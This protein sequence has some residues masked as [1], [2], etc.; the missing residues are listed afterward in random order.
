MNGVKSTLTVRQEKCPTCGGRLDWSSAELA[1]DGRLYVE[2][3]RCHNKYSDGSGEWSP[4]VQAIL[5]QATSKYRQGAFEDAIEDLEIAIQTSPNCHEAYW[6]SLLAKNGIIYEKDNGFKPTCN[7]ANFDSFYEQ[8]DYKN[9]VKYAPE[10]MQKFYKEQAD[11]VEQIRKEIIALVEKEEPFDIFLSFKKTEINSNQP[12][13]DMM[14]AN[15]IYNDLS[16]KYKV[17]Y[18]EKSLKAGTN[19]EPTIFRALQSAKVFI[20][21]CSKG[22]YANAVW[23]KNEWSRYLRMMGDGL[24]KPETM[25]IVYP[26]T[27]PSSSMPIK[28]T[29]I[30]GIRY[31][32]RNYDKQMEEF[33]NRSFAKYPSENNIVRKTFSA[34]KNFGPKKEM[35][36]SLQIQRKEFVGKQVDVND[37]AIITMAKRYLEQSN[38]YGA[39][40]LCKSVLL[41]NPYSAAAKLYM[42]YSDE[43][44]RNDS[45]YVNGYK[46]RVNCIKWLDEI[47]QSCTDKEIFQ[48]IIDIVKAICDKAIADKNTDVIVE[49]FNLVAQWAP[50]KDVDSIRNTLLN[51][52]RSVIKQSI[53]NNDLA[54]SIFN[55]VLRTY[56]DNEVE[57]YARMN[58]EFA[59]CLHDVRLFDDALPYYNKSLELID[60]SQC[61]FDRLLCMN[62]LV[63]LTDRVKAKTV[64]EKELENILKF[65]D[66]S[67]GITQKKCPTCGG[68]L[69]M[70]SE[71][72]YECSRCYN[73]YSGGA[74]ARMRMQTDLVNF[75]LVQ[76]YEG[77]FEIATKVFDYVIQFVPQDDIARNKKYLVPFADMLLTMGQY[78]LSKSYYG[79][80][81]NIDDLCHEAHWGMLKAE[82]RCRSDRALLY[83]EYDISVDDHFIKAIYGAISNND[84]GSNMYYSSF[85]EM[86]LT[87][88]E[89]VIEKS[90][91]ALLSN[92]EFEE[93]MK[94]FVSLLNFEINTRRRKIS[95]HPECYWGMLLAEAECRSDLELF[96]KRDTFP[97]EE[98]QKHENCVKYLQSFG[99]Q[100]DTKTQFYYEGNFGSKKPPITQEEFAENIIPSHVN[101]LKIL[102]A[103]ELTWERKTFIENCQSA[104]NEKQA[105]ITA[106]QR[107][108]EQSARSQKSGAVTKKNLALLALVLLMFGVVAA[109]AYGCSV[110]YTYDV[111]GDWFRSLQSNLATVLGV[112]IGVP[113]VI[114]AIVGFFAIGEGVGGAFA[115]ALGGAVVGGLLAGIVFACCWALVPIVGLAIIIGCIIGIKAINKGF[116]KRVHARNQEVMR[117]VSDKASD[118][119]SQQYNT[120]ESCE[121]GIRAYNRRISSFASANGIDLESIGIDSYTADMIRRNRTDDFEYNSIDIDDRVNSVA[122]SISGYGTSIKTRARTAKLI[123]A[124]FDL[125]LLAIAAVAVILSLNCSQVY[126]TLHWGVIL[127]VGLGVLVV[128]ILALIFGKRYLRLRGLTVVFMI[129]SVLCAGWLLL[130]PMVFGIKIADAKGLNTVANCIAAKYELTD[131]IDCY[132]EEIKSTR[133]FRG[134]FNG[135]GYTISNMSVEG[136]WITYNEGEIYNVKFADLSV[137]GVQGNAYY[138]GLIDSNSGNASIHHIGVYN[139]NLLSYGGT[140]A[141]LVNTNYGTVSQIF[142]DGLRVSVHN[143]DSGTSLD[144]GG[145]VGYNSGTMSECAIENSTFS[146]EEASSKTFVGGLCGNIGYGTITDSYAYGLTIYMSDGYCSGIAGTCTEATV[147]RC[148]VDNVTA[149]NSSLRGIVGYVYNSLEVINCYAKNLSSVCTTDSYY[150]D[151][152]KTNYYYLSSHSLT[153]A[154]FVRNS[155]HLLYPVWNI[156][157]G[158]RPT[159]AWDFTYEAYSKEAIMARLEEAGYT[160]E[161]SYQ[162]MPSMVG[163]VRWYINARIADYYGNYHFVE[164]RKYVTEDG[165]ILFEKNIKEYSNTNSTNVMRVG[166]VIMFGSEDGI[167]AAMPNEE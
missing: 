114:G 16:K 89:S 39:G 11:V 10:H 75:A 49:S 42:L 143:Y 6:Y 2:C 155:L 84:N 69:K 44:L 29:K 57:K 167:L 74:S 151:V 149:R 108:L 38:F 54:T 90:G 159:H 129:I 96:S 153:D 106:S 34:V 88:Y 35:D 154:Y 68:K 62:G 19:F 164:I 99:N 85:N 61:Y 59:R 141:L 121:T 9:A 110:F 1:K 5:E 144:V 93:A 166:N 67:E 83:C 126:Q 32:D 78:D 165:A 124:L 55:C 12:T 98:I 22:E 92:G 131:D 53:T 23:V 107:K 123:T 115:G 152:E 119:K 52:S 51:F 7:R 95:A 31:N 60:D 163:G 40:Q 139:A 21:V 86:K 132:A 45:E 26:D 50:E 135:N 122:D 158:S 66:A 25:T 128:S 71:N 58:Y 125:F 72:T 81:I 24:K 94:K 117:H 148:Y 4:K 147:E 33:I 65:A 76:G 18:S 101:H 47:L 87:M 27:F 104:L 118:F 136:P 20:L 41:K 73:T 91:W 63:K 64:E 15:N 137:D 133:Y 156:R 36:A 77:A 145:I 109:V 30:Q 97:M 113:A 160:A 142:V 112:C 43:G 48:K 14:Y 120:I 80:M 13:P 105:E 3:S 111:S 56:N 46:S 8:D 102:E 116:V 79:P 157:D 146:V 17:F 161:L 150:T 37:A 138:A 100:K 103:L 162:T 130:A 134:E 127:G 140:T 82:H 70:T 28:L